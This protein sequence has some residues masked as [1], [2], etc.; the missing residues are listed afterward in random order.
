MVRLRQHMDLK[1]NLCD[2]S[3]HWLTLLVMQAFANS[4]DVDR[5]NNPY[6]P[7]V[8]H[9]GFSPPIK[10]TSA[11]KH[12]TLGLST[13]CLWYRGE[14][15]SFFSPFFPT[16]VFSHSKGFG[17]DLLS[18]LCFSGADPSWAAKRF[19]Q[20]FTEVSPRFHQGCVS[21]VVSLVFWGIS[22]FGVPK[23]SV[24]GSPITFLNLSPSSS[25]LFSIFPQQR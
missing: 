10:T 2:N 3:W 14:V 20:G 8:W 11:S 4:S 21:F 18:D 6:N 19:H 16:A 7:M 5:T 24:E 12:S 15:P 13:P 1:L 23:G 25:T 22:C 9:G 17:A